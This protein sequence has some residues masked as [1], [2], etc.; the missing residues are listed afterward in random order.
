MK[1]N[2][3]LPV[4]NEKHLGDERFCIFLPFHACRENYVLLGKNISIPESIMQLNR[5]V[6]G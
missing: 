2:K 3:A 5:N 4:L 1:T 6:A